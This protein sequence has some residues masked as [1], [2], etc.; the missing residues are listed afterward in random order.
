MIFPLLFCSYLT[1]IIQTLHQEAHSDFLKSQ[2]IYSGFISKL[3]QNLSTAFF[4][5][6]VTLR[7]R[8][9]SSQKYADKELL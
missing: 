3:P 8:H 6:E 7:V 5:T 9:I 1:F 4:L 2:N